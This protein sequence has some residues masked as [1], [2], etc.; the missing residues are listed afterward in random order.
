[1]VAPHDA[2]LALLRRVQAQSGR[3]GPLGVVGVLSRADEGAPPVD[4]ADPRYDA[5]PHH[6]VPVSGLLALRGRTL[7]PRE[8]SV[9]RE[10]AGRPAAELDGMLVSPERFRAGCPD[11][12]L[13]DRFGMTGIATAVDLV[14]RGATTAPQLA[15]ALVARSGLDEL[16][17]VLDARI[18]QRAH[19]LRRR[20]AL[21][22]L[23]RRLGSTPAAAGL[24][25]G[26][27]RE[28]AD[29]H[30]LVEL[31]ML[32]LLPSLPHLPWPPG[33][34]PPGRWAGRVRRP[35]RDWGCRTI[36]GPTR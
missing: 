17:R 24:V 7:R 3:G 22:G 19:V 8:R 27:E 5:L 29:D 21:A 6:L 14:R 16:H 15:A 2:D 32:G 11:E 23:R 4:R 31:R 1:M 36:L 10:L 34:A 25:A 13:L 28:L 26:I 9:L 35:R 12:E 30:D 18:G 33:R 20:T